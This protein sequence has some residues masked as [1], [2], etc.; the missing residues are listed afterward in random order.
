MEEGNFFISNNEKETIELGKI[1]GKK[2]KKGQIVLLKGDLGS[3]KTRF[4]KGIAKALDLDKDISSPTYNLI[5][6]YPGD[7][8]L[9]HM[10][11]YRLDSEMDLLNIGFEEYLYREGIVVIEWPKLAYDF[12]PKDFLLINFEIISENKRRLKFKAKGKQSKKL[13]KGLAEYVDIRD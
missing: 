9:F 4:V 12:L 6:E 7:I 2:A 8:P 5:N 3:G 13:R 1:L 11:L 10:D